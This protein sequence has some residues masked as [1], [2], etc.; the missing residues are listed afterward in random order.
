MSLLNNTGRISPDSYRTPARWIETLND[1]KQ[2]L[3]TSF[4]Q[5][6]KQ[7]L[8]PLFMLKTRAELLYS[9]VQPLTTDWC[10]RG[11]SIHRTYLEWF[12]QQFAADIKGCC[13][14]FQ[15]DAYTSRFGGE[16][17]TKL[18]ILNKD[19]SPNATIVADLTQANN[20]PSDTY[21]CIMCTYVLHVIA[22]PE[23]MI[24]ELYRILK[25]GGVLLMAVPNI[26]IHYPTY[27]EYWRFTSCG[28]HYVLNK[29]FATEKIAVQTYG[30]SLVTAGEIRGMTAFDFTKAK[31]EY[32]DPRFALIVCA[33]AVK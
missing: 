30:N 25:P 28:L 19:Y 6:A 12:V 33:R 31:L 24:S 13:L 3:P 29:Y 8:K 21:D 18:D 7:M 32:N 4:K 5:T 11:I 14:E 20:I 9:G 2:L 1:V 27:S 22:E 16:R 23:K 26:T 15:D 17:V 10:Q